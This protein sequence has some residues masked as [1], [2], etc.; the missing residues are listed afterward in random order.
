MRRRGLNPRQR[1]FLAICAA[2]VGIRSAISLDLLQQRDLGT[3]L[4]YKATKDGKYPAQQ[5]FRIQLCLIS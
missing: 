1:E 3:L 4:F 5:T 2:S